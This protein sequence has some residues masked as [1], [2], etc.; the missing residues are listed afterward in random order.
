MSLL[1]GEDLLEHLPDPVAIVNI[2]HG[3]LPQSVAQAQGDNPAGQAQTQQTQ[4]QQQQQQPMHS[5]ISL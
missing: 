4:Q 1:K 3:V 2:C 5:L